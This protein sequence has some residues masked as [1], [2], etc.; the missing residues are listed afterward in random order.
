MK[1]IAAIFEELFKRYPALAPLEQQIADAYAMMRACYD[2]GGKL[3]VCGNGGSAA[4][5]EH[6]VGELMKGFLSK[7]PLS[8]AEKNR[9]AAVEDGNYLSNRLQGALPAVA[10]T[11][12]TSLLSAFANDIAPDMVYAQQVWGYAR[13]T[14]DVL[15][16][17]STSGN[18]ANI[19]NAVKT[20]A[21][22]NRKSIG[23]TGKEN[24]LLS[25]LCNICIQ[26]PESETF[27]I[28][29]L[30]QPVYHCLCA[31]LEE[32]YFDNEGDYT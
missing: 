24:S 15:I 13:K 6:I 12:Q 28:Q 2:A 21:A 9:F 29:E 23:I 5:S 31:M 1:K 10:L 14:P 18:S 3:L 27:K 7:R 30:T 11:S 26:L 4:D 22:L 25:S 16:A 20:A 8:Q 32:Y 19:V 17:L